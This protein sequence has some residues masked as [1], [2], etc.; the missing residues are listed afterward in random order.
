MPLDTDGEVVDAIVSDNYSGNIPG[1][2]VV[3]GDI[4]DKGGD[5][6]IPYFLKIDRPLAHNLV[7]CVEVVSMTPVPGFGNIRCRSMRVL[8][9]ILWGTTESLLHYWWIG[10][11]G[12]VKLPITVLP[13][14]TRTS[15][16]DAYLE[17]FGG[18]YW[19]VIGS[20]YM[21]STLEPV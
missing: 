8:R 17:K 6:R 5:L 16:L 3:A 18:P 1:V 15:V 19:V 10:D 7:V 21:E 13:A 14:S 11:G 9:G 20:R 2:M 12:P 4:L